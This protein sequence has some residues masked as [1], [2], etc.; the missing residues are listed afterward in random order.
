MLKQ[1]MNSK[2]E[3]VELFQEINKIKTHWIAWLDVRPEKFNWIQLTVE[4]G[5]KQADMARIFNNGLQQRLF[6]Q[7]IQL[8]R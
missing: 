6:I 2:E 3:S 4:L 7:E 1:P 8:K 5:Q